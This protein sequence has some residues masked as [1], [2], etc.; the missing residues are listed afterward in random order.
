MTNPK[1]FAC[2]ILVAIGTSA[3]SVETHCPGNVAS[4][5]Y[6]LVNRNQMIVS[7]SVNHGTADGF[8]FATGT[9]MTMVDPVLASEPHLQTEGEANVASVGGVYAPASFA[10]VDQI[11]VGSYK[12]VNQKA[13]V[14]DLKNPQEAAGMKVRGVLGEDLPGH[15]DMPIDGGHKLLCLDHAGVMHGEVKGP[16]LLLSDPTVGANGAIAPSLIVTVRLAGAVRPVRLKLDSGS[17]APLLSNGSEYVAF[18]VMHNAS[19]Y[20]GASGAQRSFTPLQPQ[21]MK[22]GPIDISNVTFVTAAW[23]QKDAHTSD[24]YGLL[25]LGLF[26]RVFIEVSYRYAVTEP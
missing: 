6:H 16:R 17:N 5:P 18:G 4:L 2:V 1:W 24:F 12:L 3:L 25:T 15:F 14:Y 9:Q 22:I 11:N 23:T 13:L 26:R 10:H 19:F 21:I 20:G 8:L 7:D